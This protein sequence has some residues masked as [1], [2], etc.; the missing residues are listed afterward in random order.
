M[1]NRRGAPLRASVTRDG[2]LKIEIGID[3]LAYAYLRSD[4]AYAA[5]GDDSRRPDE[6]FSITN[7]RAFAVDVRRAL[8]DE[9]GEDGNSLL[10]N[11]LDN[12]CES[13]ID[14]G[15]EHF[16]DKDQP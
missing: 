5:L 6:R 4:H 2:V 15:S 1:K 16:A 7:K 14:Q 12:A 10:T 13:A 3:T 11:V 8:T 9:L